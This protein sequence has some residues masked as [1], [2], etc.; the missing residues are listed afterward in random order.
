[1]KRIARTMRSTTDSMACCIS[2]RSIAVTFAACSATSRCSR[3][4][5]GRVRRTDHGDPGLRRVFERARREDDEEV[6]FETRP[7]DVAQRRDRAVDRHALYV[8]G[9]LRRPGRRRAP[10]RDPIPRDFDRISGALA[11]AMRCRR[12][13][14]DPQSRARRVRARS[15]R[16]SGIR[17]AAAH[18][19]RPAGVAAAAPPRRRC[20]SPP[21]SAIGLTL[22]LADAHRHDRRVSRIVASCSTASTES[23]TV[24]CS[25]WMSNRTRFGRAATSS[26]LMVRSRFCCAVNRVARMNAPKPRASTTVT[27]WLAGRCRLA[28]PWRSR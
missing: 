7:V 20:P 11:T 10:W 22:D 27:V 3:P 6:R 24:R 19:G 21:A 17:A 18:G 23:I 16:S 14:S 2:P 1:M 4:A 28:R 13:T 12:R 26:S 5:H 15:G 8:P 9:D 25:V